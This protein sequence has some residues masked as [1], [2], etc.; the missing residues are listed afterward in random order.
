[1]GK[2]IPPNCGI[3]LLNTLLYNPFQ[4]RFQEARRQRFCL[5]CRKVGSMIGVGFYTCPHCA[6]AHPFN[7]TAPRI[8]QW[9][10][11]RAGRRSGKS[12]IGAHAAREEMSIPNTRG[13]VCGPSFKILHD[14]TM[15]TL[16][17]LIPP[18][19]IADWDAE[20]LEITLIN[21]STVQFRSLDDPERGRGQGLHWLWLDEAAFVVERAWD[22]VR[23]SL[24]ENMGIAFATTSPAGYDWSYKRFMLPALVDKIPGFWACRW[25]TIDNPQF[26]QNPELKKEVETAKLTMP[27]K[28]FA[29]EYEG[30]DVNFTGSI[31]ADM[32]P[33][34]LLH[35]EEALKAFIPEWPMIDPSRPVL[36]GLDSG[37]DHP[38]G[39]VLIV[40]TEKGLII[41][42]E[43]LE[44]GIA[45]TVNLSNISAKFR[46]HQFQ[47]VRW[48]ANRNEKSLRLEAAL[49]QIGIIQ[50]EGDQQLGIQRVQSWLHA[51]QLW[52]YVPGCPLTVEQFRSYRYADNFMADGQKRGKELV[53]KLND[54]LPD[55]GRY[56]LMSYPSLPDPKRA[57][58]SDAQQARWDSMDD[59][60][61][62]EI[63]QMREYNKRSNNSV[64][65]EPTDQ[66][67]PIADF[68]QPYMN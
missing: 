50:A 32:L 21:G 24:T 20:N 23:P 28:V 11:L 37:A 43:Y 51:K 3:D 36:I 25:R 62:M 13:W 47:S 31:Y 39:A 29:A 33:S 12:L 18:H 19:W 56:A 38:F 2:R 6:T 45:T 15:P 17:R 67:Y 59:R 55:S 49:K 30:E 10:M 1:M 52:F 4:Q 64:D 54:E 66:N 58:M 60:T 65:L 68:F 8:F 35:T 34:Q 48:A 26:A 27:P 53:F 42:D 41:V 44:R 57:E 46:V 61:K 22:V 40:T 7:L 5:K 16:I 63:E 9:F 14:S